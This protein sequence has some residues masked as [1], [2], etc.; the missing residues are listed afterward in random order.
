MILGEI[1]SWMKLVPPIIVRI[2]RIGLP[3]G[4]QQCAV[5]HY[6]TVYC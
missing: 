4:N 2:G 3:V 6:V 1:G 5:L